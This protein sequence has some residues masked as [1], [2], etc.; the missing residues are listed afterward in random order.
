[1]GE[2]LLVQYHVVVIQTDEG[3]AVSCPSLPGCHSQEA[4][5][6]E[7]LVNIRE[8]V[9]LCLEVAEEDTTNDLTAEGA[10]FTRELVTV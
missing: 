2:I 4:T 1:L 3:V 7:A 10:R 8:A 9:A 5:H 6:D